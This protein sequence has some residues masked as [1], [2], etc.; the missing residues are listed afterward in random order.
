M[1]PLHVKGYTTKLIL[2]QIIKSKKHKERTHSLCFFNV[3]TIK[4]INSIQ[5]APSIM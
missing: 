3:S 2:E 5:V 4:K 1:I